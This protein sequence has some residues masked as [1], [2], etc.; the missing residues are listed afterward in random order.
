MQLA[1]NIIR[2]TLVPTQ[3]QLPGKAVGEGERQE[4]TDGRTDSPPAWLKKKKRRR[5]IQSSTFSAKTNKT[6][7]Q[8]CARDGACGACI[9]THARAPGFA[10]RFLIASSEGSCPGCRTAGSRSTHPRERL[11]RAHGLIGPPLILKSIHLGSVVF[12]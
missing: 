9:V 1:P 3:P 5:I 6:P 11:P 12:L 8:T 10:L 4:Q 7:H 2:N